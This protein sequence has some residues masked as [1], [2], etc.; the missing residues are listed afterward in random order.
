M[1]FVSQQ[2][3]NA[4]GTTAP[5]DPL[6]SET[7]ASC[8]HFKKRTHFTTGSHSPPQRLSY[9]TGENHVKRKSRA[10]ATTCAVL[11]T[12][13]AVLG[14]CNNNNGSDSRR[15]TCA[16]IHM[17]VCCHRIGFIMERRGRAELPGSCSGFRKVSHRIGT[18]KY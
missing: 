8:Y 7:H 12:K 5:Q 14:M 13:V 18:I 10:S 2:D 11:G 6:N 3:L 9:S 1:F 17:Y 16:A 15:R 4:Q